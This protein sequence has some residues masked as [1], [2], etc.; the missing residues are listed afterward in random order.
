[1]MN[2]KIVGIEFSFAGKRL[3]KCIRDA[4]K[5]S[6]ERLRR[7]HKL[8]HIP[9]DAITTKTHLP[10]AFCKFVELW[11][12]KAPLLYGK[13]HV[14]DAFSLYRLGNFPKRRE[15]FERFFQLAHGAPIP[16]R[17]AFTT[18]MRTGL[19]LLLLDLH[20]AGAIT[21]PCG[22]DWPQSSYRRLLDIN[23]MFDSELLCFINSLASEQG[24]KDDA[25]GSIVQTK[26]RREWFL[27]YG[28]K[29]LL[30]S[31]W[32]RPEDAR[33]EEFLRLRES[34]LANKDVVM[35]GVYFTFIDA[36][37][38]K[39]G[40]RLP[41]SVHDFASAGNLSFDESRTGAGIRS[42][43]RRRRNSAA[44]ELNEAFQR[45]DSSFQV[46]SEV[47]QIGP[48]FGRPKYLSTLKS[49]PGIEQP[50]HRF[51]SRWL[52]L[53]AAFLKASRYENDKSVQSALGYFNLY[54]FF[55]LPY[56]FHWHP[57]SKLRYPH[58]PNEL[59]GTAFVSRLEDLPE[60]VLPDTF[61]SVLARIAAKRQWKDPTHYAAL[62]N[63]HTF[64]EWL[65]RNDGRLAGCKGFEQPLH[66][67]DFPPTPRSM[68]T[69]KR[70]VPIR[71][72][73]AFVNFTEALK[74]YLDSVSERI[75]EGLLDS[76]SLAERL[77]EDCEGRVVDTFNLADL[78]GFVP[79]L[80]ANG[81]TIPMQF[82]PNCFEL[83]D[84]K[85][86]DGRRLLLPR[87]HAINQV[88]VGLYTGLRHNHIQWLDARNFDCRLTGAENRFATLFVNTNKQTKK[89]IEVLVNMR[90]IDILRD[91]RAWR[92]RFE[93]THKKLSQ[94]HFYN[95]NKNTKWEKILPLFA[96][97]LE[98]G[99]PHLDRVYEDVWKEILVCIQGLM[100]R[101][102]ASH[103]RRLAV[104]EPPN[105]E[106]DDP[107]AVEKRW[108]YGRQLELM[109]QEK[110][111]RRPRGELLVRTHVTPHSSRVSF[112]SHRVT[113]LPLAF[114]GTYLTGQSEATAAH[115]V[116]L[117]EESLEAQQQFQLEAMR[118]QALLRQLELDSKPRNTS[119]RFVNAAA[120]NSNLARS[121]DID[122]EQTLARQGAF[123][124]KRQNGG[125]SGIDVILETRGAN[126]ALNLTEICPYGN[127]CPKYVI[128]ENEGA[129]RCGICHYA[130]R[131]IDHLQAVCSK[132]RLFQDAVDDVTEKIACGE[133]GSVNYSPGDLD[134]MEVERRRV[135]E[136]LAGWEAA[137][138]VLEIARARVL[139]GEESRRWV[140]LKPEVLLKD[141]KRVANPTAETRYLLARISEAI[142]FPAHVGPRF[143]AQMELKTRRILAKAGRIEEAL[144][145]RVSENPA[146]MLAGLISHFMK[147]HELPA[148]DVMN[149]LDDP[150]QALT[151]EGKGNSTRTGL[152]LDA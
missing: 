59:K 89:P 69:D 79:V 30:A 95:F 16:Y 118:E 123:S 26:K 115:Y 9:A 45:A 31:G 81:Q 107:D 24:Q 70:P 147:A 27:C 134:E 97:Y 141:L 102:G 137:E 14:E 63:I 125:Q 93:S 122:V 10:L 62:R 7:I 12:A 135:A 60:E 82:I 101:L 108:E 129:Q 105:I 37:S 83:L 140:V 25:F 94:L 32:R 100:P 42:T 4:M 65:Q 19:G 113:H 1:M 23:G 128:E 143:K 121:L 117:D 73:A 112:V 130:V 99:R 35:P 80:F 127:V 22:F 49:L 142:A 136:E 40:D 75:S 148:E 98:S 66:P 149:L 90:V 111:P 34:F 106:L 126:A 78:V 76:H 92:A 41:F 58:T 86:E 110:N 133:N 114:I 11:A 131:C 39:F 48:E 120:V 64:F 47:I 85:L 57:E 52:S 38:K 55:Y 13:E 20:C 56:W 72:F 146:A 109:I 67:E 28:M 96:F 61:V 33:L 29:L 18:A 124:F 5:R 119:S 15:V 84:I 68:G 138:E 8:E 74:T 51:A 46:L 132:R 21:L 88:L 139:A 151:L 17:K 44:A 50:V 144:S 91:Q 53:Q 104:L 6:A 43:T 152:A 145:P 87:P 36:L 2:E 77:E 103:I 116:V 54:L 150:D 71:L 3:D